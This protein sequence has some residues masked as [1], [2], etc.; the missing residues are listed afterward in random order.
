MD[1]NDPNPLK[2]EVWSRHDNVIIHILAVTPVT[3]SRN[4]T[5][6]LCVVISHYLS[7]LTA[8]CAIIRIYLYPPGQRV[9]IN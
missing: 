1:L 8:L 4:K 6:T 2:K 7:P 3:T 5:S 9:F